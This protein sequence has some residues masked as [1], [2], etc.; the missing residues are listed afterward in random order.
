MCRFRGTHANSSAVFPGCL[1]QA[2]EGAKKGYEATFRC[3]SVSQM[4]GSKKWPFSVLVAQKCGERLLAWS[5]ILTIPPLG[6]AK[7]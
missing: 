4:L 7:P 3:H 6:H 1:E 5:Q 2:H